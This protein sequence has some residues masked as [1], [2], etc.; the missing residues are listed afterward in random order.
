MEQICHSQ[1]IYDHECVD[2][3][4]CRYGMAIGPDD[5]ENMCD[6]YFGEEKALIECCKDG[7][8]KECLAERAHQ[9]AYEDWKYAGEPERE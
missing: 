1:D 6:C 8:C 3:S 5:Y 4:E 7:D 2:S 9:S